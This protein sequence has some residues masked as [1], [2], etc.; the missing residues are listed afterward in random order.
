MI[1][2]AAETMP[3]SNALRGIYFFAGVLRSCSDQAA[4]QRAVQ[5]PNAKAL[6]L[7]V[8]SGPDARTVERVPGYTMD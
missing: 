5:E 6:I 2:S 3:R 8:R 4:A 7:K 1:A